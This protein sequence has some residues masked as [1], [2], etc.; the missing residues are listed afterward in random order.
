[1]NFRSQELKCKGVGDARNCIC[2]AQRKWKLCDEKQ[3]EKEWDKMIPST[4]TVGCPESFLMRQC[5]LLH[6]ATMR[7]WEQKSVFPCDLEHTL[8]NF[9]FSE[10]KRFHLSSVKR[11]NILLETSESMVC[12]VIFI[13]LLCCTIATVASACSHLHGESE[14]I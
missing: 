12:S 8:D 4:R 1:M 13:L 7:T 14:G 5:I 2:Q 10:H 6:P 11:M 9:I 3:S